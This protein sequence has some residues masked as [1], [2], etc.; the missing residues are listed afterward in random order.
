M[1]ISLFPLFPIIFT[2][3]YWKIPGW[4]QEHQAEWPENLAAEKNSAPFVKLHFFIQFVAPGYGLINSHAISCF[5][6]RLTNTDE[7][8]PHPGETSVCIPA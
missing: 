8:F 3:N 6:N 7:S 5:K 2:E 4:P 1:L